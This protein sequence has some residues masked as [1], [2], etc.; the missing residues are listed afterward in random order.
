MITTLEQFRIV[1]SIDSNLSIIKNM[2]YT[3]IDI[4]KIF[5]DNGD[6]THC[7]VLVDEGDFYELALFDVNKNV[8]DQEKSKSNYDTILPIKYGI[9]TI[10]E[11]FLKYNDKPFKIGSLSENKLKFYHKL[12]SKNFILSDLGDSIY[13]DILGI[14]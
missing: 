10:K 1:E 2:G 12:L 4:K 13:F 11:W 9:S 5:N 6:C 7:L 3:I 8:M 14:K